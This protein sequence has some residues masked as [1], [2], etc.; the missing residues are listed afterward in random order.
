MSLGWL[1]DVVYTLAMRD[2]CKLVIIDPWNELE[3][4]PEKGE[5][6]TNYINFALKSIR[7][8]AAA[9]NVHI[10]L[11]THPKKINSDSGTPRAPTG[12]DCADSASFY[13]K[14]ALGCTVHQARDDDGA[15][16]VQLITWKV[17]ETLLYG[18]HK[19]GTRLSFDPDRQSYLPYRKQIESEAA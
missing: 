15:A 5:S 13:N 6:L 9:L 10:A 1:Q 18:F 8:W 16:Y 2:S 14:P 4:L 19:G 12:Y 17:R 3:H 11:V 7:Q